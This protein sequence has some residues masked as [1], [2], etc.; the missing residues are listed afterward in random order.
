MTDWTRLSRPA[1]T[2]LRR[3]AGLVLPLAALL[4][5]AAPAA[6]QEPVTGGE[7]TFKAVCATCHSIHPPAAQAPPMAHIAR[8]Y[9]DADT[10]R[11]AVIERI[12]RW[13]REPANDR[14]LLPPMARERWGLMPP[15]QLPEA[16]AREV[17]AYV[18]TLA[19]PAAG[20]AGRGMGRGR[21]HRGGLRCRGAAKPRAGAPGSRAAGAGAAARVTISERSAFAARRPAVGP[22]W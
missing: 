20:G 13:V 12:V 17:A 14:S 19:D 11:T 16:Q 10:A 15:L 2:P 1:R 3:A 8:H 21:M 18:L 7:A 4:A 9:L 5:A 6:A 22:T